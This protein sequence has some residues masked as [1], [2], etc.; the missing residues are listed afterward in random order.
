MHSISK[1]VIQKRMEAYGKDILKDEK[2]YADLPEHA[3]KNIVKVF[4]NN[5]YLHDGGNGIV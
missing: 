5:T 3:T 4:K 2:F 1:D